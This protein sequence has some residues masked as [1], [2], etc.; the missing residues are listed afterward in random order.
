MS[1]LVLKWYVR[2]FDMMSLEYKKIILSTLKDRLDKNLNES[3]EEERRR[4]SLSKMISF[5][6][7][8]DLDGDF[9][10]NSRTIPTRTYDL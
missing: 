9:I 4:E 6:S 8:T 10:V 3:L 5:Y 2:L 1:D 7:D